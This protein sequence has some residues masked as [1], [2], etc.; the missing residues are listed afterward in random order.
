MSPS[1]LKAFARLLRQKILSCEGITRKESAP[2]IIGEPTDFRR[3]D[4]NFCIE[5]L[6]DEQRRCLREKAILDELSRP[7]SP[8]LHPLQ[9]E[10]LT[11]HPLPQCTLR[12]R[13]REQVRDLSR[14]RYEDM[15]GI[16]LRDSSTVQLNVPMHFQNLRM[17]KDSLTLRGSDDSDA[18]ST[19][20]IT[21]I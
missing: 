6:T 15:V 21:R 16:S 13:K 19:D 3:V 18:E 9:P 2:M 8:A 17:S 10:P 1:C 5:D 4:I 7:R 20:M 11:S 12:G 14:G